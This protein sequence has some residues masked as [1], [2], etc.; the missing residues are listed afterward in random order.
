MPRIERTAEAVWEGNLARGAG[1]L[2]G[3]SSGAFSGLPYRV[4]TRTGD[5]GGE[6]S[7]E[8]LLAASHAGCYAMSLAAVLTR[9][10]TPPDRSALNVPFLR[11]NGYS[12]SRSLPV[13]TS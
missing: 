3:A 11:G 6:T 9:D 13:R 2:T 8:E 1:A 12:I 4:A 5:P 10:G 7:P